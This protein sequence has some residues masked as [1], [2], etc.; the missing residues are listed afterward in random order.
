MNKKD[1]YHYQ[2]GYI[3]TFLVAVLLTPLYAVVITF[4]RSLVF[5]WELIADIITF[6]PKA[7][8]EYDK[9]WQRKYWGKELDRINNLFDKNKKN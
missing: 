8:F 6:A 7:I 2:L 1:N 5:L 3:L 4:I 9:E